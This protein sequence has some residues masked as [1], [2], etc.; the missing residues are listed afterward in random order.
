MKSIL[1]AFLIGLI[2]VSNSIYVDGKLLGCWRL[3]ANSKMQIQI[4]AR[5]GR[6]EAIG[7]QVLIK[8][9]VY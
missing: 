2:V 1:P 6:I 9:N 3:Y 5:V 4:L 7:K 8:I